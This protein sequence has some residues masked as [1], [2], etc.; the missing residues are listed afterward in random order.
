MH[1]CVPDRVGDAGQEGLLDDPASRFTTRFTNGWRIVEPSG[2]DGAIEYRCGV[3]LAV[4]QIDEPPV[5]H[6][7]AGD[8][9]A[10]GGGTAQESRGAGIVADGSNDEAP[11][12]HGKE[13]TQRNPLRSV[14][15]VAQR[16]ADRHLQTRS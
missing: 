3:E 11:S 16:G 7:D 9:H 13:P 2:L 12:S 15:P 14:R 6:L 8:R 5:G 4:E 10:Q 1:E